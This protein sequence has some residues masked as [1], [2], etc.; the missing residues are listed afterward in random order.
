M[1]E[2]ITF[3]AVVTVVFLLLTVTLIL[4]TSKFI[5]RQI[6]H[7]KEIEEVRRKN[8]A[9]LLKATLSTQ[10]KE[11]ERIGANLHDDIGPLLSSF[12]MY[13]KNELNAEY[14][15]DKE[16]IQEIISVL[17]ENIEHVRD[18]S[19]ELVPNVLKNFGMHASLEELKR[20][21][22]KVS[23]TQITLEVNEDIKFEDSIALSLYRIIQES[24]NNAVRHGNAKNISINLND[25][26]DLFLCIEDNGQGFDVAQLKEGLGLR[27]IEARAKSIDAELD[28]ESELGTGT[29][30]IIRSIKSE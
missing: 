8:E 24:I 29:K 17:E 3:F 7:K 2:I 9:A 12:K 25:T 11:R 21:L 16:E 19:R 26:P 6:T 5:K 27:N 22:E 28:I 23:D 1:N 18:I 14:R 4:F 15:N 30:I 10:E 13:F 20:R